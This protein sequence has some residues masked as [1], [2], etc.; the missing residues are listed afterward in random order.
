MSTLRHSGRSA[1]A[2]TGL[3]AGQPFRADGEKGQAGK[4]GLRRVGFTLVELLVVIA[5]IAVLLGLLLPAVQKA[6]E[7]ASRLSCA[8]NLKQIALAAHNYHD[9]NQALPPG[10]DVQGAGCLARLLP[11]LEQDSQFKLFS[12]RPAPEGSGTSGPTEFFAWFRDPLNRPPITGLPDVPRPRPDGQ[13][14][15]GSEGQFKVLLCPSAPAVDPSSTAVQALNG[16]M[17]GTDYNAPFGDPGYYWY[18]SLPGNQ[19]M[20]RTNYVA[21]AGDWRPRPDPTDPTRT[22]DAHGL[23]Y[24]KSRETFARVTD[25]TSNTVMFAECAGGLTDQGDPLLGRKWTMNAW[26]WGVWFSAYGIC[27]NPNFPT[28]NGMLTGTPEGKNLS[29]F[30]AGS[31]HANGLCNVALADGSV[32]GLNARAID[33]LSLSYITGARDGVTRGTDF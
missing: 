24:Y 6:R 14:R 33:S 29:V 5:I 4:P 9:A 21:S 20:G 28:C 12:Y 13:A 3:R 11:Y 15:Y 2:P 8:N 19:I 26:A 22:V 1:R 25:G 31:L 16:G 7:A 30:A 23:F 27:P 10:F 18:S 32:K 17:P